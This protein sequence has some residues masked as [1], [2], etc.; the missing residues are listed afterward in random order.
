MSLLELSEGLDLLKSVDSTSDIIAGL[1]FAIYLVMAVILLI[2]MLI[3]LLSNTYQRVQ[4]SFFWKSFC[5]YFCGFSDLSMLL[6][7]LPQH[8]LLFRKRY[9]VIYY[10]QPSC[11]LFLQRFSYAVQIKG[12]GLSPFHFSCCMSPSLSQ[13]I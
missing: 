6:A 10:A 1:L 3:A 9:Y 11:A 7:S 4:V 13:P 2:N 5:S 12:P 8:N